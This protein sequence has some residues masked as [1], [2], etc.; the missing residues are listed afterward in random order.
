MNDEMK[1]SE[2][3]PFL[4]LLIFGNIEN[5]VLSAQGVIE[6]ADPLVVACASLTMVIIWFLI[7]TLGT[8]AAI[9][10]S[11]HIEFIGGLA[12]FILGIQSM[13]PLIYSII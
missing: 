10:Y 9:K 6:G 7:G 4:G 11:R 8:K 12:I 2:Y 1:M 3:K 13:L 5:L